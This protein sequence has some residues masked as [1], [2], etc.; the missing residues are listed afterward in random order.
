MTTVKEIILIDDPHYA[1]A[2]DVGISEPIFYPY[3]ANVPNVI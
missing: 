1:D 2:E 3:I